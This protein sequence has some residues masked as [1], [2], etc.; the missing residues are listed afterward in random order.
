MVPNE[1]T[2]QPPTQLPDRWTIVDRAGGQIIGHS[3]PLTMAD[4]VE[5]EAVKPPHG[6]MLPLGEAVND[7]VAV[8]TTMVATA[9]GV[10]SIPWT[11]S[12][13]SGGRPSGGLGHEG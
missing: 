9:I 10:E 12:V 7:L 4:Q 3:L 2:G 1:W 5:V 6:G 11:E 13:V 8:E